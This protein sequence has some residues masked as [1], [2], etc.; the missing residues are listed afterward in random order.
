MRVKIGRGRGEGEVDS[1]NASGTQGTDNKR[2]RFLQFRKM[3][4]KRRGIRDVGQ[5]NTLEPAFCVKKRRQKWLEG[6]GN[7]ATAGKPARLLVVN[8]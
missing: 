1:A 4:R 5:Y 8:D 7:T 6:G 3:E 2:E